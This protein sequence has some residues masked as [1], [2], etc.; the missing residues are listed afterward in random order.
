MAKV[1]EQVLALQQ[2]AAE[3]ALQTAA[4]TAQTVAIQA[5][6]A[7]ILDQSTDITDLTAINKYQAESYEHFVDYMTGTVTHSAPLP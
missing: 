5:Q 3:L 4:I 2:M 1:D 6:T 7:A